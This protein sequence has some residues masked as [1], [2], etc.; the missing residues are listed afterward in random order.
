MLMVGI[1]MQLM[2]LYCCESGG[3]RFQHRPELQM[4]KQAIKDEDPWYNYFCGPFGS[5]KLLYP[6]LL[7]R[8]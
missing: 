8:I 1:S 2:F 4:I 6:S 5:E 7:P 3:Y